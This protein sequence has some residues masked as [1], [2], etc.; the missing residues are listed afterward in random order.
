[1]E[2]L[3]P[4]VG[5]EQRG[6]LV[7]RARATEA[8]DPQ[9]VL[10]DEANLDRGEPPDPRLDAAFD[11]ELDDRITGEREGVPA[12]CQLDALL[13]HVELARVRFAVQ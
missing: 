10:A 8:R 5:R 13:R 4:A 11:D 12:R 1:M 6:D 2:G 9:D 7:Q 3:H